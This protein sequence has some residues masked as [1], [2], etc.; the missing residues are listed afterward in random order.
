MGKNPWIPLKTIEPEQ[1][2]HG[3]HGR[4]VYAFHASMGNENCKNIPHESMASMGQKTMENHGKHR[5]FQKESMGSMVFY[6]TLLLIIS[7]KHGKHGKA[8]NLCK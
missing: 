1:N 5:N 2:L 8:W 7:R 6:S 3:F 4:Y